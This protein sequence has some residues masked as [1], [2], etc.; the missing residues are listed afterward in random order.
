MKFSTREDIEA[1]IDHVFAHV[2]D[3]A[4]FERQALRRG[5]DV[6]RLDGGTG[7]GVGSRW[8]VGFN[9]RGRRRDL[10][11]TV[12]TFDPPNSISVGA[13]TTGIDGLTTIDLVQLSRT[14]TRLMVAIEMR[15]TTLA[16]RLMIQSLKLAKSSLD[17]RLKDRMAKVAREIEISHREKV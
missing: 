5:A 3:H 9:F 10:T 17:K 12:T 4:T 14:R 13:T 11:A 16:A 8:K 15:P 2:T 1:P 6:Q 7:I